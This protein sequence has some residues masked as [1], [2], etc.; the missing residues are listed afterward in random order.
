MEKKE[1]TQLLRKAFREDAPQGDITSNYFCHKK[2]KATA[3]IIAKDTGVL[4]GLEI[5]ESCFKFADRFVKFNK[6]KKDG[7]ELKKGQIIATIEG[8]LKNILLAERIGLNF[9][10]LLSGIATKTN[11]LTKL[12]KKTNAKLL[13]TRKTIPGLRYLSKYAVRCGGGTNHRLNLSDMVLIKDNHLAKLSFIELKQRIEKIKHKN[14]IIKIEIEAETLEQVKQ[15]LT[16]PVD[17]IM[18][19][20]MSLAQMK[21]AVFYRNTINPAIKLEASG[22][23]NKN[24]ILATAKTGIDYISV[25]SITHSFQA[26][27]FS[28][29]IINL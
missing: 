9:L 2:T 1:I 12:I 4:A 13:D 17:I 16:L 26:F 19:D 10:Q 3:Q 18:L 11:I 21:K 28:L 23:I 27:D 6:L 20:N 5:C 29:K 7:A 14:I 24:N 15:S 8:N 25:G 22:N